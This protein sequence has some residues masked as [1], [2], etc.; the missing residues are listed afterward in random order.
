MRAWRP[1]LAVALAMFAGACATA[2]DRPP[3]A[4]PDAAWSARRQQLATRA[5]W[6][7]QGRVALRARDEGWQASLAWTRNADR[8]D[9]DL[10]GPLGSGRLR[11]SQ[12]RHGAQLRDSANK[13]LHAADAEQLLFQATGWRLP[14][15]G[16]NYWMLGLPA[17][18]VVGVPD[19]DAWG[20]LKTLHQSG[21]N[22]EFLGYASFDGAELPSKLFIRRE[23]PAGVASETLEVR[24]V[25]DRWE[26]R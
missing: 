8:H 23:Q 9:I 19:L 26:L 13:V 22:I 12:D 2:P 21:W 14:F 7:L 11:L 20:R 3:P 17:P 1:A 15:D 10:S 25:I 4:D 5:H 6:A 16:L 18:G 24:L